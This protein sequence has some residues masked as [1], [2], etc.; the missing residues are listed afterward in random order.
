MRYERLL[1]PSAVNMYFQ[2]PRRFYYRYI[3]GMPVKDTIHTIR[4]T[5]VHSV[6]ERF[7]D[8]DKSKLTNL[9]YRKVIHDRISSLFREEWDKAEPKL[10]S[11]DLGRKEV[12]YFYE[13]ST[14]Q[15]D[16]W[17]NKFLD[18][19]EK[20]MKELFMIRS[21]WDYYMPKH[22]ELKLRSYELGMMGFID[23]VLELGER[24]III[25]FKTSS[26]PKITPDYMLQLSVYRMLYSDKYNVEPETYLW[27][28]RYGL[29]RVH[30][31]EEHITDAR[32]RIEQ[33]HEA[34]KS[35]NILDYPKNESGL[36][37][38]ENVNS[39]G[40][41]DFYCECFKRS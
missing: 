1:S 9:N 39:K 37:K 29:K 8:L 21:A 35:K 10:N 34:L 16:R 7:F 26:K 31:L 25:D 3:L 17:L 19:M 12:D 40:E 4:G 2:C 38:W 24:S 14:I 32:F 11:L 27:F 6:L 22:R 41:C 18:Q 33:V 5:I 23:Q 30:I 15:L 20:K 36:C 13:D 28:L